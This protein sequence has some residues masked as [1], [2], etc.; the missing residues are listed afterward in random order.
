MNFKE[1][2]EMW[3]RTYLEDIE[4]ARSEIADVKLL[5][6]E[7][8]ICDLYALPSHNFQTYYGMLYGQGGHLEMVYARTECYPHTSPDNGPVRMYSFKHAGREPGLNGKIITGIKQIPLETELLITDI[9]ANL[10]DG[11]NVL[12]GDTVC[13]DGVLQAVRVFKGG[14]VIKEAVYDNAEHIPLKEHREYLTEELNNLYVK[15]EKLMK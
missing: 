11:K 7:N 15:V 9:V 5:P 8:V 13:I 12:N 3:Y 1:W 6:K 14:V 2:N 4:I 10:P